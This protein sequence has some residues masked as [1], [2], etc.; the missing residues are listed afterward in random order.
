MMF[1]MSIFINLLILVLAARASASGRCQGK[2][3]SPWQRC[4]NPPVEKNVDLKAY[5][6][7]WYQIYTNDVAERVSA[8]RCVTANYTISQTD[9]FQIDV[10]NCQDQLSFSRPQCV[11]GTAGK[12]TD[13]KYNSQLQVRF[14]Q[15]MP[16]G[17]YNIAALVGLPNYG[18]FGAVVYSCFRPRGPGTSPLQSFFFIARSPFASGATLR[19]L[20]LRLRCNGYEIDPRIF[21]KTTHD[22]KCS[23]AGRDAPFDIVPAGRPSWPYNR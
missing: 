19:K 5:T 23:Y 17:D 4:E 2:K 18:Y 7:L 16:F 14:N 20:I 13:A 9:P 12:R 1:N 10:L 8:T 6:G 3:L 22:S 11:V 15:N 21:R